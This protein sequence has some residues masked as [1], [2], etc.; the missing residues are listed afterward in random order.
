MRADSVRSGSEV[1]RNV[2]AGSCFETFLVSAVTAILAIRVYLEL[3][4]FP[5]VGG[6]GLHVAHMLWG[7]LLMLVAVVLLLAFLG[8]RIKRLAAAVG[9]VG[10]GA[11]IDELGKFIT[12]DND[13]FYRPTIGLIYVIF[14]VLFLLFRLIERRRAL[15]TQEYLVNAA[16]MI[17]EIIIDG[18]RSD[19]I[20]RALA[21]LDKSGS[22]TALADAIRAAVL[23]AGQV[24]QGRPSR[25]A[26][27][28]QD[29]RRAYGRF[30]AWHWFQRAIVLI[31]TVDAVVTM[32]V[33]GS[34]LAIMAPSLAP[35]ATGRSF[36]T[37]GYFLASLAASLLIVVGVV[38]LMRSRVA[39]Y[40]WF[41]RSVLVSIFLVQ[42]FL[43]FQAQLAAL[44]GL[45]VD[46]VLL[47][48]L[49]YMLRAEYARA[50][51]ARVG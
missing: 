26:R 47:G 43:F 40:H 32:L 7:G 21:L 24:K 25:L 5:Q 16:D 23:S 29:A 46:L 36:V 39:A 17:A 38:Q 49:N 1:I 35:G 8:K 14:I 19:E 50:E 34:L 15:S 41:K 18:A 33:T 44:G 3:A 4:G 28:A 31:F 2:D 45:A 51:V 12:R 13:Y 27:L 48:G 22:R 30:I 42:V 9:G 10:F 11:F 37:I 20:A 6:R